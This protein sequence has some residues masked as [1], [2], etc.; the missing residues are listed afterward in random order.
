MFH[1]IQI[2]SGSVNSKTI[3]IWREAL[4]AHVRASAT[5]VLI[6]VKRPVLMQIYL[7]LARCYCSG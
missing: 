2:F 6:K 7:L 5:E 4:Q 3:Q 1:N